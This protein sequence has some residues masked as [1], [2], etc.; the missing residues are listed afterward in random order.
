MG[1]ERF[2]DCQVI[3]NHHIIKKVLPF[4]MFKL[5]NGKQVALIVELVTEAKA[6]HLIPCVVR[7]CQ[8]VVRSCHAS[9]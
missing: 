6:R 7:A 9:T 5:E 3:A 1:Q 8:F 2:V 4:R